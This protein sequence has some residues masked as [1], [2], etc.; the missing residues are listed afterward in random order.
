MIKKNHIICFLLK[1]LI[2]LM[3][4]LIFLLPQIIFIKNPSILDYAET[5]SY[6]GNDITTVFFQ[7]I[8]NFERF[9]P[10]YEISRFFLKKIYNISIIFAIMGALLGTNLVFFWLIMKEFK[11]TTF[12]LYL[13]L[14]FLM[15]PITADSYWRIG[16]AESF[17]SPIILI[18]LYLSHKNL[19]FFLFIFI[20]IF[21]LMKESGIFYLPIFII[22]FFIKKTRG[23]SFLVILFSILYTKEIMIRVIRGLTIKNNY[24]YYPNTLFEFNPSIIILNLIKYFLLYPSIMCLLFSSILIVFLLWLKKKKIFYKDLNFKFFLIF[25][26]LLSSTFSFLLFKNIQAYYLLPTFSLSVLTFFIGINNYFRDSF[27]KY[28]Y[29]FMLFFSFLILLNISSFYKI[30]IFW[31]NDYLGDQPLLNLITNFKKENK[32]IFIDNNMRLD[33]YNGLKYLLNPLTTSDINK[34]DIIITLDAD[35]LIKNS[36]NNK[37]LNVENVCFEKKLFFFTKKVC[38]WR[39]IKII[40]KNHQ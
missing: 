25:L 13:S 20:I 15:S 26:N 16:T 22:Y 1:S 33:Y 24:F 6:Q 23:Y 12:F 31:Q 30:I 38:K 4:G 3:I 35:T 5:F 8:K 17:L 19:Y 11:S 14:I 28:K 29:F 27:N 2:I 37:K 32:N 21:L 36:K 40:N 18:I 34:S 10:M 9:R 7:A 39:I